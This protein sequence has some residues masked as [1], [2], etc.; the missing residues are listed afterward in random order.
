MTGPAGMLVTVAI[1][2]VLMMVGIVIMTAAFA[3]TEPAMKS[4]RIQRLATI[5][6][7]IALCIGTTAALA[8][9]A[10]IIGSVLGWCLVDWA[11]VCNSIGEEIQYW[12][13]S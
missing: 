2:V 3:F 6:I 13:D 4:G 8:A 10:A 11:W 12:M 7:R 1:V 5:L 9:T